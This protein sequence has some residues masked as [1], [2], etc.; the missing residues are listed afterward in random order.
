[1][2][3]LTTNVVLILHHPPGFHSSSLLCYLQYL[4]GNIECFLLY[5]SFLFHCISTPEGCCTLPFLELDEY[6]ICC[7]SF[8]SVFKVCG[9]WTS[10]LMVCEDKRGLRTRVPLCCDHVNRNVMVISCRTENG[11]HQPSCVVKRTFHVHM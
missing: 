6:F 8:V 7:F 2:S 1:M 4:C 5:Q 9:V 10:F 3:P 11:P